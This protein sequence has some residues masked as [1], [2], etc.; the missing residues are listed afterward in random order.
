[1][2]AQRYRTIL[3]KDTS[4]INNCIEIVYISSKP[5]IVTGGIEKKIY[6]YNTNLEIIQEIEFDGWIRAITVCD[7]DKNNNNEFAVASG[8]NTLRV[9]KYSNHSYEEFWKKTFEKKVSA[10]GAG[11]INGDGRIEIIAGS[12]DNIIKVFDGLTGELLWELYFD[13]WITLIKIIDVNWDGIPE[14]VVGL[15]KGQFGVINGFTGE[16]YWDYSFSKK[17]NDCDQI[18]LGN[19]E[20]PYLVLGGDDKFLYIFDH[21]GIMINDFKMEDRVLS[22][23]HGDINGD[24]LN[25]IILGLGNKKLVVYD[26]VLSK[27]KPNEK[28]T[29]DSTQDINGEERSKDSENQNI[30]E[31][32][33][34]DSTYEYPL[35]FSRKN[36]DLQFR[37]K[38]SLSNAVTGIKVHDIFSDGI[39]DILITGYLK[40]IKVL[41]DAFFGQ[42]PIK[43]ESE[44]IR[45]RN[46]SV[47]NHEKTIKSLLG[48]EEYEPELLFEDGFF[49]FPEKISKLD[50][51]LDSGSIGSYSNQSFINIRKSLAKL[52]PIKEYEGLVEELIVNLKENVDFKFSP[53]INDFN[54][55]E[56]LAS[57][58]DSLTSIIEEKPI[59]K[60]VKP[61]IKREVTVTEIPEKEISSGIDAQSAIIKFLT[62]SGNQPKKIIISSLSQ[63]GFNVTDLEKGVKSLKSKNIISY[64]RQKPIGYF[65][66]E[67]MKEELLASEIP[68]EISKGK[69]VKIPKK[70]RLKKD[71][72]IQLLTEKKLVSTKAELEDL[73]IN[74]GFTKS[75]FNIVSK[76]L[77]S[78]NILNYS[79]SKPRGY[80]I[81]TGEKLKPSEI[82]PEEIKIEEPIS[83]V[84][85]INEDIEKHR[86]KFIKLLKSAGVISSKAK[87][88]EFMKT[89][90]LDEPIIELLMNKLKE[91]GILIYSRKTPR[92]YSIV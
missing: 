26:S 75:E 72:F 15:K 77:M 25:E 79:R 6:V 80:S 70:E 65:I 18:S 2:I 57:Q 4:S 92:G 16:C 76:I 67:V 19:N 46:A 68:Q 74:N 61:K 50:D 13:D 32:H 31:N 37:W 84:K 58:I 21:D 41:Q 36:V 56:V 49:F 82:K 23:S 66:T 33:L 20:F 88:I 63:L 60:I 54:K 81:I 45:L 11:D 62:H 85:P 7:L 17:I 3:S 55:R 27:S 59:K 34:S 9:F 91:E 22:I 14:I 10:V 30:S 29:M 52:P 90:G 28:Q 5:F 35:N 71:L 42:D 53:I 86:T 8:D 1:M 64:S 87:L 78:E 48:E 69:T 51:I 12:W 83:S 73:M 24:H 44:N 39:P 43:I 47:I 89:K 38:A 40:Q